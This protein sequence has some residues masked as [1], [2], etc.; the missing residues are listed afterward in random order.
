VH[1]KLFSSYSWGSNV[2]VVQP[3][4]LQV[5]RVGVSIFVFRVC[6]LGLEVFRDE[7]EALRRLA[8]DPG[9]DEEV[10]RDRAARLREKLRRYGY[11]VV[12]RRNPEWYSG[13][14]FQV[15]I[16]RLGSR[17]RGSG[18]GSERVVDVIFY[19]GLEGE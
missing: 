10:L 4:D 12:V 15:L 5:Y 14:R 3:P 16:A 7:I 1:C 17:G 18:R 8:L 2:A 19:E 13:P 6:F 11:T 9:V